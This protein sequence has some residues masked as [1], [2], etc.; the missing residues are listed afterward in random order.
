[1]DLARHVASLKVPGT[2]S[3]FIRS[4]AHR[5]VN[6]IRLVSLPGFTS[7]LRVNDLSLGQIV[8][9]LKGRAHKI[10]VMSG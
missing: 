10:D 9:N 1:M 5:P 2:D 6:G 7:F 8:C 3:F 4:L